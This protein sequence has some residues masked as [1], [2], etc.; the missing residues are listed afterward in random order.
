MQN[1][2][3]PQRRVIVEFQTKDG[4]LK[5]VEGVNVKFSIRQMCYAFGGQA[6]I[7]I[8]NLSMDDIT[9]LTT[10]LSPF[11]SPQARK[12]VILYCGYDDN[13]AKIF[14][15]DI[16]TAQPSKNGADIW[17]N[18]KAMKGF[19]NS[20]TITSKTIKGTQIPL[21][22]VCQQVAK[23]NSMPLDF[24]ATVSKTLDTFA[25]TGSLTDAVRKLND[26]AD[27]LA[28]EENGTL[29]VIDRKDPKIKG[30]IRE[31]SEESGMIGFPHLDHFGATIKMLMDNTV[32]LGTTVK[33][34]SKL[35]PSA[36]GQYWVYT[37]THTGSLRE[38][39]FYTE[40]KCRRGGAL[41][42]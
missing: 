19:F 13:V 31:L 5:R 29:K 34:K 38:Q 14:E 21:K 3:F 37:A 12:K 35:C 42:W 36:N 9:Y 7:Q 26:T 2:T 10:Y 28:F 25:F 33:L 40:L 11:L 24:Q 6:Q 16:W 8:A 15:G 41:W 4:N 23:W 27:I 30:G 20:S 22:E 18:I 39:Q 32:K 1:N 17:L